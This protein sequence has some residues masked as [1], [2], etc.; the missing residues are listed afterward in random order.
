MIPTT[1]NLSKR[2]ANFMKSAP[3]CSLVQLRQHQ[4]SAEQLSLRI[5]VLHS[6]R[7]A[8]SFSFASFVTNVVILAVFCTSSFVPGMYTICTINC[9]QKTKT[10]SA[11]CSKPDRI[12]LTR[13]RRQFRRSRQCTTKWYSYIYLN[14][15]NPHEWR[16]GRNLRCATENFSW[17]ALLQRTVTSE[18]KQYYDLKSVMLWQ[19]EFNLSLR[20]IFYFSR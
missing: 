7:L 3:K 13:L 2:E 8:L 9:E 14:N 10:K 16:F 1:I 5:V 6:L 12:K 20:A 17:K 19:V 4:A 18:N 15:K 11:F